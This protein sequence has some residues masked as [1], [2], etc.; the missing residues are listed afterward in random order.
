MK[1]LDW[2]EALTLE[3]WMIEKIRKGDIQVVIDLMKNLPESMKQKYREIW[4]REME[5]RKR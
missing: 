2:S 1:S 4:K 5:K 3:D